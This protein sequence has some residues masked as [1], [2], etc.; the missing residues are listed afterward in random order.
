MTGMSFEWTGFLWLLALVPILVAAYIVAI[1][2]RQKYAVRYASLSL[3]KDAAGRGPGIRRHIPAVLFFLGLTAALV[4]LAR[5]SA[6]VVL[7]SEQGTVILSMD[8]SGSMRAQDIKPSR[9][10]A[11]K[12]A[13][14]A[15]VNKQP[16]HVRIGIVAFSGTA[17]LVQTPTT[18]RDQLMDAIGRLHPQL[19][20]AVGNGLLA[21]LDAI[22][23]K[24]EPATDSSTP[25]SPLF[26]APS[27]EKT[28]PVPPGSYTSAVIVLMSDGQ[29]N[30]GP[31]PL[32][33]AEKAANLGVRVF[34]VGVGTKQGAVIGWKGFSFRV[35]LDEATLKAI[36]AKTGGMYYKAGSEEELRKI[37]ETLSTRVMVSKEKTEVT[38]IFAGIAAALLLV[39]G[40]LSL[41]WFSR[42]P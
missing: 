3:V 6:R 7:P 36:A 22:F 33:A 2:K 10:D 39:M 26:P 14:R 21:S 12:E 27:E 11:V 37:Y 38:A 24:N 1:R 35:Y 31:D 9:M 4:A 40:G 25:T 8:V 5:P 41:A 16:R 32:D 34:T 29:S 19:Y 18:D 28:P 13:A 20:T 42:L 23:D 30:Q 17:D 15:F